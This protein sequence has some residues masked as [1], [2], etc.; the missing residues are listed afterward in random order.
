VNSSGRGVDSRLTS[1]AGRER[2]L[3]D[4]FP[5]LSGF[6][7]RRVRNAAD[8]ED[9]AQEIAL[10]VYAGL[11]DLDDEARINGWVWRVARN[12]VVDHYRRNSHGTIGLAGLDFPASDG[13]SRDVEEEV[14]GW[15]VPMVERL[16][17]PYR[18]TVQLS[19]LEGLTHPAIARRVGISVSGVKSRVQRGRK[20]LREILAACCRIEFGADGRVDAYRR[21][22]AD[23]PPGTC[24]GEKRA[25]S[26]RL[27]P[28]V[29][30]QQSQPEPSAPQHEVLVSGAQH[31]CACSGGQ[32]D[33]VVDSVS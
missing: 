2:V 17:E 10:K 5:K 26:A 32:H 9:L 28:R 7:A 6:L 12:A 4:F 31:V 21:V 29:L 3:I 25:P 33:V 8:V 24:A 13:E 14:L 20:L 19:E 15:L 30:N 1:A 23:C 27:S 18:E 11:P 16:P 22:A